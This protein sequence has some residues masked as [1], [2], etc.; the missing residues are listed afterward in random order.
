[1]FLQPPSS[2]GPTSAKL[3]WDVSRLGAN[4]EKTKIGGFRVKYRPVLDAERGEFFVLSAPY[5]QGRT[6]GGHGGLG[7]PMAA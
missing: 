2:L 5:H 6:Q 3:R 1:V 7:P 4:N